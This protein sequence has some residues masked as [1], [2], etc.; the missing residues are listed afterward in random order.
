MADKG[1][2]LY[3]ESAAKRA[4]LSPQE[5]ECITSSEGDRGKIYTPG[6]IS[7]S[8][9]TATKINKIGAVCQFNNFSGTSDSV[10]HLK[11]FK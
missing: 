7:N 2:N 5:E 9:R 3:Y 4:H 8:Q 1:L 11:T 6:T 10:K